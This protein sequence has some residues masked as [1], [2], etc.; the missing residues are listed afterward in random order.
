MSLSTSLLFFEDQHHET[1]ESFLWVWRSCR[2]S[3][4][5]RCWRD[6]PIDSKNSSSC[7]WKIG[8]TIHNACNSSTACVIGKRILTIC[9]VCLVT[10][11]ISNMEKQVDE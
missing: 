7:F 1:T 5:Q 4:L 2:D 11:W 9:I 10:K 3:L 6:M 8:I